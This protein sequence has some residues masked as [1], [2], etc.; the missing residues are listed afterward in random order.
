M[1]VLDTHAWVWWLSAPRQL[2]TRARTAIDGAKDVRVA[3]ISCWEVATAVMRGRIDLDREVAVWLEHAL[4]AERVE[5]A[6]ITPSI[7]VAA[8]RLPRDFTG[9][10]GDRLI[11]ATAIVL[12]CPLVTKD[13]PLRALGAVDTIW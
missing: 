6:H 1:I 10:P 5:I 2:S 11:A 12:R 3:A 8:S 7:A 4:A 9:D 13:G